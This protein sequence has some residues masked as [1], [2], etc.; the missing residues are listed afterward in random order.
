MTFSIKDTLRLAEVLR[1]VA[2]AEILPRFR[3]LGAGAIRRKSSMHDLVTDADEAAEL[4]ITAALRR[5]F[6]AAVIVGEESTA[7]NPGLLNHLADAELAFVVDP[8]DGTKN[9]ASGLPLFG[10]MAG[11]VSRGEVLAGVIHDPIMDDVAWAVRGE[12]AWLQA[13]D[14]ARERL[15]VAAPV[16]VADMNGVVSWAALPEPMRSQVASNLARF[17]VAGAYRC[18]A[19]EYRLAAAG[20]CDFL[21]YAKLMPWDHAAGWLLHKEAGG[22]SARFDGSPY[23]PSLHQ[24]G[25]ICATDRQSWEAIHAALFAGEALR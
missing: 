20:Q 17:A 9:F 15:A 10:V 1:E 14:G 7:A 12:G 24:G 6:P 3:K 2:R 22:Y 16:D 23:R 25:L 19:H 13:A 8:I 4:A 18:A 21:A 5:L 11:V